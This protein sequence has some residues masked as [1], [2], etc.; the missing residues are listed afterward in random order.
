[1]VYFKLLP[2]YYLEAKGNCVLTGLRSG[3]YIEARG[4]R[5]G[6]VQIPCVI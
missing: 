2:K 4:F 3:K 1:M 5:N 6:A